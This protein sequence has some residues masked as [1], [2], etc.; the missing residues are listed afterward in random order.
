MLANDLLHALE[1]ARHGGVVLIKIKAQHLT[2]RK[3]ATTHVFPTL[4]VGPTLL[5]S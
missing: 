5:Q 1:P 4:L 3:C 2:I